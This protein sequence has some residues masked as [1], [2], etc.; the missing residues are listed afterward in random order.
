MWSYAIHWSKQLGIPNI[1]ILLYLKN[2]VNIK[3]VSNIIKLRNFQYRLLLGKIFVND[4]LCKWKITPSEIRN[5]CKCEQKEMIV[6]LLVTCKIVRDIWE[7]LTQKLSRTEGLEWS[8][9]NIMANLIHPKAQHVV[10]LIVL[11]TNS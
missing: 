4:T 7:Y 8:T 9:E 11:I 2:F 6:H 10:N 5:I 3:K 1:D